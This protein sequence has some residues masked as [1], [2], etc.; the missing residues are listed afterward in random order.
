M[1][2]AVGSQIVKSGQI[3]GELEGRANRICRT[4]DVREGRVKYDAKGFGLKQ[5]FTERG[6]T[7]IGRLFGDG[8]QEF[9]FGHTKF[10]LPIGPRGDVE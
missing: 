3:V 8:N 7:D 10:E 6:K 2:L 4:W 9:A 5:A 1:D